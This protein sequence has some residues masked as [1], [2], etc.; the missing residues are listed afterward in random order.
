MKVLVT[1]G[2]GVVGKAAVTELV[3]HGHTVRLLSRKAEQDEK[4]WPKGVQAWPASISD[5]NELRGCAEG[6]DLVLHA[7]GIMEESPPEITYEIIN[8]E[9]T[10]AILREAE[11]C[12]VGRFIYVSS[13]GA[14]TGESPYHRSKRRAEEIVRNFA[15]GW[16]I[17]RPGNV[18]GP[19]D[20]VVSLMLNMVRILPVVPVVGSGEDKF[21][22]IW[23][24]D[25]AAVLVQCAER[26]DLQGRVFELAGEEKTSLNEIL[27]RLEEITARSPARVSIPPFL[28]TAGATIAGILGARLPVNESQVIMLSEGNVIRTPGANALPGIF[29][30]TPTPLDS[31]LRMLADAQPEQTPDQGVGTLKR[32]RFWV[33]I[34]GSKLSPEELFARFQLRFSELTPLVDLRAEPGTPTVLSKGATITMAVPVRGH[35]QARVEQLA[36]DSATLV[37]LAGH[38]LAGAIR[39]LCEQR[40]DLIRFE[41]QVYDRPASLA[42]WLVMRAVGDDLQARSWESLVV[43]MVNESGGAAVRPVQH[44]EDYL[45]EQKAERLE[46]WV[47]ELVNDRK[48]GEAAAGTGDEAKPRAAR[49]P[50]VASDAHEPEATLGGMG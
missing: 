41:V 47:K 26:T 6:C 30:I 8:V 39:F 22:P 20:E 32:K 5:A 7:A 16:I 24:N 48:R 50:P 17:L 27:D 42:D 33:D 45:D 13:L 40:A 18:Y 12:K 15:G 46:A 44:E 34:A 14:E 2:T 19:G 11:R 25:L 3:A 29:H 21:Q 10:R 37:T 28:A 38:P 1:G 23:V 36:P 9:G 49:R 4:E 43:A 35:V 31:G